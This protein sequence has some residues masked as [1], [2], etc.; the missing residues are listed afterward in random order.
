MTE[1]NKIYD[2][3]CVDGMSRLPAGS[4]D[5]IVTSPPYNI[6]KAYTTYDDTIPRNT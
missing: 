1:L 4:V 3:D 6:G 5:V 2:T